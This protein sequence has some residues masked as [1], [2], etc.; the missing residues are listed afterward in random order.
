MDMLERV[1]QAIAETSGSIPMSDMSRLYLRQLARAA[2]VAMREPTSEMLQA[3][4]KADFDAG[5][6]PHCSFNRGAPLDVKWHAMIDAA[7]AGK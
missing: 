5:D 6:D 2:I 4:S 7:L 1:A 3:A